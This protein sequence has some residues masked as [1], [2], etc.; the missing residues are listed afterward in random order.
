[1][2]DTPM[3]ENMEK[4]SPS[5]K[6]QKDSITGDGYFSRVIYLIWPLI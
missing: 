6:V 4:E 1:M 3:T 5:I 2:T